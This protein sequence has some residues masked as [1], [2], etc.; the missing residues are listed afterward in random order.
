MGV[1]LF[2]AGLDAVELMRRR[3]ALHHV[4]VELVRHDNGLAGKRIGRKLKY[5]ILAQGQAG[6][7]AYAF[8]IEQFARKSRAARIGLCVCV[9]QQLGITSAEGTSFGTHELLDALGRSV[10]RF[11]D[12]AEY[13]NLSIR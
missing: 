2:S 13:G 5:D 10:G 7:K 12:T 6:G 9:E 3:F 4:V 11:A 8:A 1:E